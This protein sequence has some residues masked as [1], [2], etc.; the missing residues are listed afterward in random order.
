MDDS[1]H[2]T[3][4]ARRNREGNMR[5]VVYDRVGTWCSSAAST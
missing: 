4:T 5:V 3:E 1:P 2:L